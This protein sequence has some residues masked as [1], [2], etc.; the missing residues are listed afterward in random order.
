MS[1]LGITD[2]LSTLSHQLRLLPGKPQFPLLRFR[3]FSFCSK[4]P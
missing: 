4:L 2:I 1:I 3:E